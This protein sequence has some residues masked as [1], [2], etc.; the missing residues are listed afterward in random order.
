MPTI[1]ITVPFYFGV[2]VDFRNHLHHFAFLITFTFLLLQNITCLL[3]KCRKFRNVQK[4]NSTFQVA[5]ILSESFSMFL[6]TLGTVNK[7]ISSA[8]YSKTIMKNSFLISSSFLARFV[9]N[10]FMCIYF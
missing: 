6:K 8:V 9:F 5:V 3:Q 10:F 7:L 1:N 2:I 4:K